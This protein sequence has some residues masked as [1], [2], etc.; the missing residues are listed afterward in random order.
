MTKIHLKR[1]NWL[2]PKRTERTHDE[3][4]RPL[5]HIISLLPMSLVEKKIIYSA[6]FS[7]SGYLPLHIHSMV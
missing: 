7:W 4:T 6:K 1:N 5:E 3:R 2:L